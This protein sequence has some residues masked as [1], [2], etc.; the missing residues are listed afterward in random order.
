[1]KELFVTLLFGVASFLM[2]LIL[3][4]ALTYF[5][6]N[7]IVEILFK[8]VAATGV[9]PLKISY[10]NAISLYVAIDL[11]KT[12]FKS[13]TSKSLDKAIKELKDAK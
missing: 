2:Y 9:I 5:A 7:T 12:I 8:E 3:G 4:G 1:M 6:Y 11:L 10:L 13:S